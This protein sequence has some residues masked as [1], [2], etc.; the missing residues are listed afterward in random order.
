M[1]ENYEEVE[2]IPSGILTCFIDGSEVGVTKCSPTSI[3][4]RL[5]DKMEQVNEIKIAGYCFRENKYHYVTVKEYTLDEEHRDAF[6]WVYRYEVKD[7]QYTAEIRRIQKEYM[8]YIRYK[9]EYDDSTVSQE[10][11][12]YPALQDE[13]MKSCGEEIVTDWISQDDWNGFFDRK[14]TVLETKYVEVAIT[15]DTPVKYL[16]FLSHGMKNDSMVNVPDSLWKRIKRIYIGNQFCPN[17]FPDRKM[18]FDLLACAEQNGLAVTICLSYLRDNKIEEMQQLLMELAGWSRD[19]DKQLEM[20]CND[21]GYLLLLEPYKD[22]LQPVLGVLLNK[23]RKDPRYPYK[24]G[25]LNRIEDFSE[26][27]WN[28][29]VLKQFAMNYGIQRYEYES[30]GYKVNIT[31]GFHSLHMPLYQ[32]NTAAYCTLFANCTK[33]ERGQQQLVESCKYPCE[34]YVFSYPRHLKMIGKY[35][36]LFGYDNSLLQNKDWLDKYLEQGIDRLVWNL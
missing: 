29:S 32:T 3:T 4:V 21:V 9:M 27:A 26:N 6:C 35:N 20:V 10:L 14:G 34:R 33:G 8:S 5:P 1:R 19:R 2:G 28:S 16:E 25:F 12:G 22:V 18:L 15:L 31:E 36:S 7:T 30:C 11:T 17:L 23:R 24:K 13:V